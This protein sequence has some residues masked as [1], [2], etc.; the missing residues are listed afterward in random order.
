MND[1]IKWIERVT[2]L[3]EILI[4]NATFCSHL[5]IFKANG[6]DENNCD[7]LI[8]DR[9]LV[10]TYELTWRQNLIKDK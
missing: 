1:E 2:N 3:D 5:N 8:D 7:T 4:D 9:L 10:G 6:D